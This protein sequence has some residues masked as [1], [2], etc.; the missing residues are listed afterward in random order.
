MLSAFYNLAMIGI[1]KG[2]AGICNQYHDLWRIFLCRDNHIS[3]ECF[4]IPFVICHI[5]IAK[6]MATFVLL[7]KNLLTDTLQI[8]Q[9]INEYRKDD[10]T[11]ND[12]SF[13]RW[14]VLKKSL[15]EWSLNRMSY[16]LYFWV[17]MTF[18]GHNLWPFNNSVSALLYYMQI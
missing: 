13:E 3:C 17:V 14:C 11:K 7:T 12:Y 16:R 18:F 15:I 4:L 2:N 8:I 9:Q 6:G 1:V 10:E 5:L